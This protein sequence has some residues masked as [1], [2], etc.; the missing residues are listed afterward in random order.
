ML[1]WPFLAFLL[2]LPLWLLLLSMI[3]CGPRYKTVFCL[4]CNICNTLDQ[5]TEWNNNLNVIKGN[6]GSR[7]R[8]GFTPKVDKELT[9]IFVRGT[10]NHGQ[11]AGKVGERKE[12]QTNNDLPTIGTGKFCSH[13]KVNLH[14]NLSA[15]FSNGVS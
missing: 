1:L 13:H 10:G 2:F 12:C 5:T 11:N 15:T 4:N 3:F 8:G 6:T 7:S 14:N 9:T